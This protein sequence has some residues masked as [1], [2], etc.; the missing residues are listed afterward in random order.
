LIVSSKTCV[1]LPRWWRK[2]AP[3]AFYSVAGEQLPELRPP[4]REF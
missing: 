3:A 1:F 4:E 2:Q